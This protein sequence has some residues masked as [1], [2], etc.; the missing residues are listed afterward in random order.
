M[1]QTGSYEVSTT[2]GEEVRAFVPHPLPPCE[3]ALSSA[4]FEAANRAAE[5][6]LARLAGVSG[7]VPSV[8]WLL[9][10]AVRKEAL[11]TSQIEGTQATLVDLFDEE[12]GFAVVNADDV[13]EVSNY[14]RAFRLVQDNL[15]APAGL[16]IS[17][18]LLCDAHRMLLAGVRGS[19]KQPGEL[20]RSQNW[21]GGPRPGKAVFVPPPA[22]RVPALLADVERF[23]HSRAE[24]D[25]PPLVRIALVHAQFETIHPFLDGNGRIG[26]LLIAALMEHWQLLPEPLLYLSAY[27]KQHQSMYYQLLSGIRTQGDWESWIAFFLDGVA[28]AAGEAERS[29]VAIATLINNDRRRLLAAPKATSASYRL[30]EAL[31]L[32]PRFTVEHARQKLDTTF[33]TANAAV[34][35]LAELGIVNEMT[36][37]KKNRSY[38]YQAYIDL[39]T[40]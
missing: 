14:L 40:Q 13:E 5:M 23:I 22:E 15:R 7:L 29:I 20:R 37:Q 38:G 21:I 36:G 24:G 4:S 16:P 32:M 12:A 26:R 17:V 2:L 11:L 30:F 31:P 18:R 9:Y 28:T 39:L 19:G 33:P 25:L 27:L 10:G 34:G 3:P 8:D 1:R 35:L 6:A